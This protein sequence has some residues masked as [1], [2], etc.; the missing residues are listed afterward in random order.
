MRKINATL[1]GLAILLSSLVGVAAQAA[2]AGAQGCVASYTVDSGWHAGNYGVT[3]IVQYYYLDH[4]DPSGPRTCEYVKHYITDFFPS[5]GGYVSDVW[6]GWLPWQ[7]DIEYFDFGRIWVTTHTLNWDGYNP[8][9]WVN[10]SFSDTQGWCISVTTYRGCDPA[11]IGGANWERPAGWPI[12]T[13]NTWS[14]PNYQPSAE[15]FF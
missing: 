15:F 11:G 1:V 8:G 5:G 9:V 14:S 7:A 3:H 13:I 2:P 12:R 10:S 4:I 6:E